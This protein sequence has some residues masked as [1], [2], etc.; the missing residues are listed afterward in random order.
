MADG[1]QAGYSTLSLASR[2]LIAAGLVL[3][4]AMALLGE[5]ISTEVS[6]VAL[7]SSASSISLFVKAYLEPNV[8]DLS[9]G[10]LTPEARD[11]LDRVLLESPLADTLVS[12]QIWLPDGTVVY[13]TN[14][15]LEGKVF[16]AEEVRLAAN[17]EV[18]ANFDE[19]AGPE[20]EF[21][22]NTGLPIVEVFAPLRLAGTGEIVAVGAYYEHAPWFPK[23]VERVRRATW[24]IVGATTA[25]MLAILF[26]IV[27]RGSA[28]ISQQRA[29]LHER[30]REANLLATQNEELRTSAEQARIDANESNEQ[31]IARI[32]SDLHDG[33]IQQLSMLILRLSAMDKPGLGPAE[34]RQVA[35]SA[36]ADLMQMAGRA[37]TE[38]RDLSAGL[39]L[40]EIDTMDLGEA[41]RLA[42]SRHEETTGAR[43]RSRIDALPP[44][45]PMPL[46]ICAYR[47]V[48]EA[49]NNS[50]KH[51]GCLEPTVEAFCE[52]PRLV[53]VVED[54]RGAH[55]G[56]ADPGDRG[57]KLGIAGIRNRVRA[58]R[59]S[60]RIESIGG[61]G[62]RIT[63]ILPIHDH[64]SGFAEYF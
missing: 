20:T 27:R 28:T 50:Y 41:L 32:G 62:T 37:L 33:P 61:T 43:V 45:L 29:A 16:P 40:P 6:S 51:A 52:G 1:E 5:W 14:Q 13:A 48:Q 39:S 35:R 22:R 38:L 53:L 46:K 36:T 11:Q 8:Q 24:A 58:H 21:E 44:D 2:F 10:T 12:V 25:A 59:G 4:G 54:T 15:E 19:L 55:G 49:L 9:G 57:K 23:Q 34:A 3:C 64:R 60:I 31:L 47:I 17:G 56:A 18:I 63:V 30:V 7:R 42:I 26:L